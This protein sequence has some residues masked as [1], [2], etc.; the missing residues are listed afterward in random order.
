LIGNLQHS[1]RRN[2]FFGLLSFSA[3]IKQSFLILKK[4]PDPTAACWE[5][6]VL[7]N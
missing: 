6:V 3:K 2:G 5:Y 1:L 4:Q 7:K